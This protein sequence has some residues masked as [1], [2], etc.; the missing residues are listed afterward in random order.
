MRWPGPYASDHDG[1][2]TDASREAIEFVFAA[3]A[4]QKFGDRVKARITCLADTAG[5]LFD[6]IAGKAKFCIHG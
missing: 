4:I 2:I 1:Q 3:V 5:G 6:L